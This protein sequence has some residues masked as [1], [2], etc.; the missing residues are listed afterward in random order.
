MKTTLN[1][2]EDA[3][4]SAKQLAR[5]RRQSTGGLISDLIRPALSSKAPI[6]YRNGVPLLPFKP[7][8][9][10]AALPLVNALRDD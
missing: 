7:R 2:D 6:G 3:L 4:A 8:T 5:D 10:R 1:I 9:K